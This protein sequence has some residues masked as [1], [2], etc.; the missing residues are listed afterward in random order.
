LPSRSC[1]HVLNKKITNPTAGVLKTPV[2]GIPLVLWG[3]CWK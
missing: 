2:A 1:L 3:F